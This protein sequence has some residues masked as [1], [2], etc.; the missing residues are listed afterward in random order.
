MDSECQESLRLKEKGKGKSILMETETVL[1][2][3]KEG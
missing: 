1:K 2:V 3:G